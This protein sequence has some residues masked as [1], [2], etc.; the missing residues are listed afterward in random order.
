[1]GFDWIFDVLQDLKTFAFAN[2]LPVLAS[3][4]DEALRAAEAEIGARAQPTG[5]SNPDNLH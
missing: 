3:K 2:N 1:M 4:A 5:I